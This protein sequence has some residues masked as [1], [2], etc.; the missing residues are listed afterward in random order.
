MQVTDSNYYHCSVMLG[1]S[2]EWVPNT[3][4]EYAHTKCSIIHNIGK[5]SGIITTDGYQQQANLVSFQVTIFMFYCK[6]TMA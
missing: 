4:E 6:P 3:S 5:L 2:A 1:M